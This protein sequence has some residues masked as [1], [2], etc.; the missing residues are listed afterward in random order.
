MT[1]RKRLLRLLVQ[2]A[3]FSAAC[4]LLWPPHSL[5]SAP[6]FVAQASPFEAICSSVA[7]K[8]VSAGM[9][10]GW[11]IAIVALSQR[12]FFCRYICP[13][14]LL[15]EGASHVGFKKAT[16]WHR[17]PPLGQYIALLTLI[18]A[19]VG[20][21]LLLW[22]D[23]LAI[24]SSSFALRNAANMTSG[25][26]AGLLLSV[27]LALSVTSGPVWCA[28]LCPLGGTQDLLAAAGSWFKN[29]LRTRGTP[30]A[31]DHEIVREEVRFARR[32]LLF[33][34]AGLGFGMWG[35]KAGAARGENAPLRPPGACGEDQFAGLCERCGGCVRVCPSKII[36]PYTGL[37]GISG[38]LTPSIRYEKQYCLEDCSACTQVCPSGALER[39]DLGHKR[40]YIIG[41][42]L[43]DGELCLLVLGKKDCDACMRACPFDAVRIHWDEDR[44]LAYPLVDPNRCNGCGA[45][46][47]ACP[48]GESK[49]IR[50]WRRTDLRFTIED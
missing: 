2:L 17:C 48:T 6:K 44:Y 40:R 25:V 3:F 49:A 43:V 18:G 30:P 42:A 14:G 29:G 50:V 13:T 15:L 12:R 27:L 31:G 7:L 34:V 38:L 39:M 11:V 26:L 36:Y 22:M 20:Y 28:R 46:E 24:F 45:C 5:E 32:A 1:C 21:P 9:L 41:E 19:V 16:W 47:V 33:A 4:V 23:P 10:I 35:K 8:S 37:A